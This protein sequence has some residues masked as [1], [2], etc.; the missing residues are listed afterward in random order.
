LV[1]KPD[2][3]LRVTPQIQGHNRDDYRRVLAGAGLK[4]EYISKPYFLC[5]E[6]LNASTT[7][8]AQ[9]KS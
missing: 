1:S 5:V 9:L 2:G 8:A 6:L 3:E 7:S 4:V